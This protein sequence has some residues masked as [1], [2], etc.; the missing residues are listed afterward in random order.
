MTEKTKTFRQFLAEAGYDYLAL[1]FNLPP[2]LSNRILE[3]GDDKVPET[4]VYIDPNDPTFGREDDPHITVLY[5]LHSSDPRPLKKLL[6]REKS[7]E[8]TLGKMSLFTRS[9]NF[10]VLKIDVSG[11]ELH[12][13]H[14]LFGDNLKVTETYPK[15]IPHVTIAY[16][17]K[18]KGD[19]FVDDSTFD[20][21][22][23]TVDSFVLSSKN[24]KKTKIMIG[25]Q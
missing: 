1:Q 17:K 7:F 25:E 11:N 22:T 3:W 12:R 6:S 16:L 19:E 18:S 21:E 13:I 23:M 9:D 20:G 2:D 14:K 4:S 8:I 10:D 15:Y 5:G 24:G